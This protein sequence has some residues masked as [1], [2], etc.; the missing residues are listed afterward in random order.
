MKV[1]IW[2]CSTW[3]KLNTEIGLHTLCNSNLVTAATQSQTLKMVQNTEALN[4][5]WNLSWTLKQ[6]PSFKSIVTTADTPSTLNPR[7]VGNWTFT[8]FMITNH[9]KHF[10]TLDFDSILG[11][12]GPRR[13]S[14]L[15]NLL[16]ASGSFFTAI[17][18]LSR[19]I[20][21]YFE[22]EQVEYSR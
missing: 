18:T 20:S 2:Y 6:T 12:I 5:K 1:S 7:M 21:H 4:L 3:R 15:T 22:N 17:W 14:K 11:A 9:L 19:K 10:Q 16:T 8:Q 13:S